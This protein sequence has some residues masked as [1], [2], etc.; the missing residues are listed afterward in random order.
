MRFVPALLPLIALVAAPALA[1]PPSLRDFQLQPEPTPTPT[2]PAVQGPVDPEAPIRTRPRA[3]N[4][5]APAP[6]PS[7]TPTATQAPAARSTPTPAPERFT[8]ARP[9]PAPASTTP[10]SPAPQPVPTSGAAITPDA[11]ATP[12]I[13]LPAA[14]PAPQAPVSETTEDIPEAET[15][16]GWVWWLIGAIAAALLGALGFIALRGRTAAVRTPPTIEKPKVGGA[17]APEKPA[18]APAPAS[19]GLRIEAKAISLGRSF[20]NATLSYSI[21]LTNRSGEP[22]RGV[23]VEADMTTAHSSLPVEQQVAAKSVTL[24]ALSTIDVLASGGSKQL[25]G[26]YRLPL[27]DIRLIRQGKAHLFVPLL[28]LRVTAE[29]MEPVTRTFVVGRKQVAMS[30]RLNPFRLDEMAQTYREIGL[31]PIG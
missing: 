13:S 15:P 23:E 30:D 27:A 20:R 5:S 4:T 10:A 2:G 16:L 26:E 9:Q 24:P 17:K 28:R 12:E 8:P 29:G 31:R 3:A 25:T 7:P 22:L 14:P 11:Q 6:T 1:A 18:A 21:T 19:D